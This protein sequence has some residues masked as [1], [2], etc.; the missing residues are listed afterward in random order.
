MALGQNRLPGHLLRLGLVIFN[1]D[2]LFRPAEPDRG[3]PI[4]DVVRT[5]HARCPILLALLEVRHDRHRSRAI[6]TVQID[7]RHRAIPVHDRP[8]IVLLHHATID[9]VDVIARLPQTKNLLQ[10][11]PVIL[12]QLAIAFELHDLLLG[13]AHA[14]VVDAAFA[15]VKRQPLNNFRPLRQRQKLFAILHRRLLRTSQSAVLHDELQTRQTDSV[16]ALTL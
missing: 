10:D 3:E 8:I 1:L 7:I 2:V 6:E 11:M 4:A 12:R 14:F 16:A 15:L 9:Q 5:L 13:L